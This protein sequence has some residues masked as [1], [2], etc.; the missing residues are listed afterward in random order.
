MG[1]EFK[2]LGIVYK[3]VGLETEAE[4]INKRIAVLSALYD[5]IDT[6]QIC[7]LTRCA[8]GLMPTAA[9]LQGF[10]DKANQLDPS[11]GLTPTDREIAALATALLSELIAD[12][13]P[14]AALAV[15]TGLFGGTRTAG[16]DPELA[17]SAH[18]AL[19]SLQQRREAAP[20]ISGEQKPAAEITE[21]INQAK[22]Q[23][24]ANSPQN[25][26]PHVTSA[27]TGALQFAE[28]TNKALTQRINQL[29]RYQAELTE[30]TRLQWWVFGGWSRDLEKPFSALPADAVPLIAAK[31]LSDQTRLVAGPYAAPALFDLLFTNALGKKRKTAIKLSEAVTASPAA[32]RKQWVGAVSGSAAAALCPISNALLFATESGD[33]PDWQPRFE[34]ELQVSPGIELMPLDIS[35]QLLKERRLLSALA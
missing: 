30:E 31:E 29:I 10:V 13:E 27:L 15:S 4:A 18:Q 5:E 35:R 24:T 21:A 1:K 16:D 12:A 9:E 34:R 17:D 7:L 2:K 23:L 11:L 6:K 8:L 19:A 26:S 28:Q 22:T 25:A 20:A 3:R 32:W 14:L 33:Q